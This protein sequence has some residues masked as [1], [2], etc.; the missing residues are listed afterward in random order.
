M[1]EFY[2]VFG[3]ACL[4]ALV[5]WAMDGRWPIVDFD[6]SWR[7][8]DVM[9]VATHI[10][11]T[12]DFSTMP[13]LADALRESGCQQKAIL[14]HC[15]DST[16]KHAQGCWVVDSILRGKVQNGRWCNVF[17]REPQT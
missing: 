3:R 12:R 8:A 4:D 17:P 14:N 9:V 15:C 13:I 10:D 16:C 5:L 1:D 6:E 7:T 2:P 11:E